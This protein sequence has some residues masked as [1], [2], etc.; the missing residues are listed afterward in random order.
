M[1]SNDSGTVTMATSASSG[2]IQ[3][4]IDQHADERQRLGDQL[5]QRLL[6]ALATLSMSL[7]TRLS[8]SPRCWRST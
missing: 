5:A 4:I 8:R 6:Q 3:I 1:V 2:E 7:V